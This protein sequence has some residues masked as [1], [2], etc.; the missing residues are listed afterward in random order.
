VKVKGGTRERVNLTLAYPDDPV[1]IAAMKAKKAARSGTAVVKTQA[2]TVRDVVAAYGRTGYQLRGLVASL[3]DRDIHHV[4]TRDIKDARDKW[5]SRKGSGPNGERHFLQ[6]ARA[7]FNWAVRE[8]YLT[9]TPF[10]S[11]QGASLISVS[12]SSK[13][14]RRLE[15]GEEDRIRAVGD[16]FITD[17]MV[18]MLATGCRP[19]ELRQ[20]KRSEVRERLIVL[21]ENAKDGEER[22]VPIRP[23][24]AEIFA[25]R[26]TDYVFADERGRMCSRERLCEKWRAVCK[27]ANVVDLHLHD[28]RAEFG[29]RMLEAAVPL[30]LVRDA[31][32]HANVSMTSTYLRSRVDS[33]D[34]AYARLK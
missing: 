13:R 19:G 22:R 3:G 33:L 31:L 8:N 26:T 10:K 23:E 7:F 24:L 28:L 16:V 6:A 4:S 11:A 32:G 29:S 5:Q 9:H 17:F 25:R 2:R 20:L 34:A 12:T 21:A 30:H 15:A 14:T 18:A 1:E 27:L